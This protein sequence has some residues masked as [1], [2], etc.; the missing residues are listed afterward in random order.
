MDRFELQFGLSVLTIVFFCLVYPFLGVP[1]GAF[2]GYKKWKIA[3]PVGI[4]WSILPVLGAS[5]PAYA[6]NRHYTPIAYDAVPFFASA[7]L[8]S[9]AAIIA[10][11]IKKQRLQ[12]KKIAELEKQLSLPHEQPPQSPTPQDE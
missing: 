9:I 6:I 11:L 10:A 4:V 7:F 3:I 8:F 1:L 2:L 12:K 5:I